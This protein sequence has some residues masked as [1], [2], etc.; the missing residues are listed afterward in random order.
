LFFVRLFSERQCEIYILGIH[1]SRST[2]RFNSLSLYYNEKIR[3]LN[4][5]FETKRKLFL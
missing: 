1:S 5:F 4:N 2:K 3:K